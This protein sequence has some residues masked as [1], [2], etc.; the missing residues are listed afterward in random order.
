MH[1]AWIPG[2]LRSETLAGR[3]S[4]TPKESI[5]NPSDSIM[6][7]PRL[8]TDKKGKQRVKRDWI[9]G[10]R[11]TSITGD[12]PDPHEAVHLEAKSSFDSKYQR[13]FI[14]TKRN[15]T[16]CLIL[17]PEA[18]CLIWT[19]EIVTWFQWRVRE[20][21]SDYNTGCGSIIY[22]NLIAQL[23]QIMYE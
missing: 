11:N 21:V 20:L 17:N 5:C 7:S 2:M 22:K 23:F 1:Y 14:V 16:F 8:K 6:D 15:E 4:F 13:P 19:F 10:S 9:F 3:T 18:V 12:D